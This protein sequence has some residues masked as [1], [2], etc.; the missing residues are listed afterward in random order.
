M[1][2]LRFSALLALA[3][4]A[5]A[6]RVVPGSPCDLSSDCASPLVCRNARCRIAC[7]EARDCD[8]GLRCVQSNEGPSCSL[9]PEEACLTTA[10]CPAGLRCAFGQCRSEC[11]VSEDCTRDGECIEGS[12][13][14]T[15]SGSDAGPRADGG[16][17]VPSLDASPCTPAAVITCD[18]GVLDRCDTNLSMVAPVVT[19]DSGGEVTLLAAR[20]YAPMNWGFVDDL[21]EPLRPEVSLGLSRAGFGV[22]AS[23]DDGASRFL[24]MRRFSLEDL[25]PGV[26]ID[27]PNVLGAF[28][29]TAGEDGDVVRL[30][31]IR[32]PAVVGDSS[33]HAITLDETSPSGMEAGISPSDPP[34]VTRSRLGYLGGTR[35]I[36]V[37]EVPEPH[38]FLIPE[39]LNVA[40]AATPD[41][42]VIGSVIGNELGSYRSID[43]S[44]L[45]RLGDDHVH[46]SGGG[47]T[48]AVLYTS[49]DELGLWDVLDTAPSADND[50]AR[51]DDLAE[52]TI[53][54]IAGSPAIEQLR[55][56]AANTHVIAVPVD[57]DGV[58]Y[59]QFYE[60]ACPVL[61]ECMAPELRGE[62][63]SRT[64]RPPVLVRLARLPGGYALGT[65]EPRAEAGHYDVYVRFVLPEAGW[66]ELTPNEDLPPL[67]SDV[68]GSGWIT[69][70]FELRAVS[71]GTVVTIVVAALERNGSA[72][73]DRVSTTGFRACIAR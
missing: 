13:Q 69:G 29:A 4:A 49:G 70:D 27:T 39:T 23:V 44:M 11:V 60:V 10:D 20:V 47:G 31:V 16:S 56:D 33:G 43:R 26:T 66:I 50:A 40:H 59:T 62:L 30:F 42:E 24:R 71:D 34:N 17:D 73:Q 2:I 64:G 46:V 32:A 36:A 51:P 3:L 53:T 8:F 54:G 52:H 6:P 63:Q 21:D 12:C 41:R 35:S 45:P 65:L 68:V 19:G 37:T 25:S 72:R 5:C 22:V 67:V 28:S 57:R 58:G 61:G 55:D 14:E 15:P 1:S 18:N 48:V 9:P 38:R 7:L